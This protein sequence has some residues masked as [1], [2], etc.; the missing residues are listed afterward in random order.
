MTDSMKSFVGQYTVKD[1]RE[2]DRIRSCIR[3][4]G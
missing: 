1:W 2:R 3:V 4:I